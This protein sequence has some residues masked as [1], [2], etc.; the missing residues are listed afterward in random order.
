MTDPNRKP[1]STITSIFAR[2]FADPK[3]DFVM[4]SFLFRLRGF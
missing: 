1:L 3:E 4:L 2:F